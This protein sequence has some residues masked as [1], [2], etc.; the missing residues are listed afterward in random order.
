MKKLI[1]AF[2][3]IYLYTNIS[4]Q[5]IIGTGKNQSTNSSV[6]LEFGTE[7]KGIVLPYVNSSLVTSPV[8]GTLIFD[9]SDKKHKVYKNNSWADLTVV[10]N[11][12]VD[13]SLQDNLTENLKSKVSV[14]TTTST[15]GILVLEDNN[16]AMILPQV[17][18]YANITSPAP[19]MMV[20]DTS[21]KLLCFFNGT[22]WSF[23]KADN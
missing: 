14:G 18:S 4:A 3:A 5:V 15:S 19:G 7:E 11:G 10:T 6:S 12:Q 22:Q 16:K 17:A 21:T 1:F 13:T 8:N 23:W 9:V 2:L 20:F